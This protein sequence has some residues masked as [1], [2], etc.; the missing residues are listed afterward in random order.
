M[1]LFWSLEMLTLCH[2]G[3]PGREV[4]LANLRF[5]SVSA[6]FH[7]DVRSFYEGESRV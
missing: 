7:A 4:A 5:M 2:F 6:F 3:G 1:E